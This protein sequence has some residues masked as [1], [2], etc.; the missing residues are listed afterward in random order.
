[1]KY[2]YPISLLIVVLLTL[3]PFFLL[4]YGEEQ[5][6]SIITGHDIDGKPILNRTPVIK[7]GAYAEAIRTFDSSTCGDSSSAMKQGEIYEGLYTY[8][9]LLR[10]NGGPVVIPSLAAEMPQV[11]DD[12]L[13]WT[14]KIKKGV[15]YHR[16][17]CFGLIHEND[18][19]TKDDNVYKTREV[20]AKDFVLAFKRIADRHNIRADL[21]WSL[22]KGRIKGISKFAEKCKTD[23][24]TGDFSR[25]DK[26]D[27]EG[28][29]ALDDY[30]LQFKLTEPFP[31]LQLILSMHLYAPCPREAVDYW[32][33]GNGK[34]PMEDRTVEFKKT[35]MVIGTG[36][37]RLAEWKRKD[38]IVLVRNPDF[39][40][41]LYPSK[42]MPEDRKKGLLADAGK[43]VPF[44]DILEY[45][46][47]AETYPRWMLFLSK[48]TDSAA[49][50]REAYSSIVTPG[51]ELAAKWKKR[52]ITMHKSW[53]PSVFWIV[54]NMKDPLF[55]ASP[56]LRRAICHCYDVKTEI[57]LLMNDRALRARSIV[58]H[59]FKAFTEGKY[60]RYDLDEAKKQIEIA[61]IEL[62]KAGVL[63][64][65][66][67]IPTIEFYILN[68][69][70]A[71]KS[72][73][74]ATRQFNKIGLTLKTI[75]CDWPT[76]QQR[77][78]S[79]KAQM[80]T[81]GWH[82]D[83]FDSENFL[84]LYYSKNIANGTNNSNYSD[85]EFDRLYEK[86]RTMP[87]SPE[88]TAIY[89][90]MIT[91]ICDACPVLPQLE[92]M[93]MGLFYDWFKNIKSHPVG[94]GYGKYHRIDTKL[95]QKNGGRK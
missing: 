95:R 43:P 77:V 83:Y 29:K 39:R 3:S 12:L 28:I 73:E 47:V 6:K 84:Q 30:T 13:T 87:D 51:K 85:P 9:Y 54:F 61:K 53:D 17:P 66:D 40:K 93:G 35:E 33:T 5:K 18:P 26:L 69:T 1:M 80:Y 65:D 79:K 58:P 63:N 23:Y 76:L 62:K 81:M 38:K 46:F 70:R 24:R 50:P 41:M 15:L 57:K 68:G 16:N 71:K 92:P 21:G 45:K 56:A 91:M 86:V 74:F 94:Y 55:Q 72:A 52:G 64:A 49:I 82:A 22:I 32:L 11:S 25:F 89:K 34:I 44:I 42:G 4:G 90:Q 31:Q 20:V 75:H 60:F 78:H 88:R 37:Y 27:I 59:T 48:Q 10:K 67:S 2:F 19:D 8:H 14:I 36:A 7:Y